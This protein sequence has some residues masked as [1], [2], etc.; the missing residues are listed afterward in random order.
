M[1]ERPAVVFGLGWL[2]PK[3]AAAVI[4]MNRQDRPGYALVIFYRAGLTLVARSRRAV[5]IP[6]KRPVEVVSLFASICYAFPTVPIHLQHAANEWRRDTRRVI[7]FTP[8]LLY[9]S[10][11]EQAPHAV[12]SRRLTQSVLLAT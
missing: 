3:R 5:V 12:V 6:R 7:K 9:G 10:E 11:E 4:P 1:A 8:L 2:Q